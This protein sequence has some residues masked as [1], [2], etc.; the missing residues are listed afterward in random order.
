MPKPAELLCDF[1]NTYDVEEDADDLISPEKLTAWLTE[2]ALAGAD[3]R[4]EPDDLVLARALREGLRHNH[5]IQH[6]AEG[7][8]PY[9]MPIELSTA[10]SALP[11]LVTLTGDVPALQPAV[12]GVPGGL[13]RLAA[14]IVDARVDGSWPRLKVCGEDSCQWAFIDVSK[15][16]SRSW[17]SMKVCGNRTKTRA[18]RARRQAESYARRS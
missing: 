18:Y 3:D 16:R 6:L 1:V 7:H 8:P 13:A 12:P 2:R 9:A 10:L 4:G 15:N 11:L 17:C 5:D 14:A